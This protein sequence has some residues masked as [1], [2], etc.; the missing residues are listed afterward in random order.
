MV[1]NDYKDINGKL[2]PYDWF[3]SPYYSG[4]EFS[5]IKEIAANLSVPAD[6]AAKYTPTH[7]QD[8]KP[9]VLRWTHRRLLPPLERREPEGRPECQ[10]RRRTPRQGCCS[11][12]PGAISDYYKA[13]NTGQGN[14]LP[15][16]LSDSLAGKPPQLL[17]FAIIAPKKYCQILAL[18]HPC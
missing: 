5:K 2:L 11:P 13:Q 18:C 12:A 3:I 10:R 16:P 4:L 1:I 14:T 6:N 8:K 15:R 7:C 9:V 17:P